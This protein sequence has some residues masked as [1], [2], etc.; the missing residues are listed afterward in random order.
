MKT[1]EDRKRLL[2]E[3][4]WLQGDADDWFN[5]VRIS[6]LVDRLEEL[7]SESDEESKGKTV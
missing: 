1:Q 7:E 2:S 4:E 6:K 3:I 5:R